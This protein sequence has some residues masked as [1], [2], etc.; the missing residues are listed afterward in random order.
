MAAN[1]RNNTQQNVA[2]KLLMK[3]AR[4]SVL[5]DVPLCASRGVISLKKKRKRKRK[6]KWKSKAKGLYLIDNQEVPTFEKD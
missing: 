4:L 3:N 5:T 2:M 6:R 1:I